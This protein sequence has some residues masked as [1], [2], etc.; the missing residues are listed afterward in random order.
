VSAAGARGQGRPLRIGIVGPIGCGKSTVA[1]WL[2]ELGAVVIDA[3]RVARR[4]TPPGSAPLA[5][6]VD[7]FGRRV[8]R[9]DGTLD[10]TALGRIVFADPAQLARLEAIIHPAVRP[11]IIELLAAADAAY[12][13]GQGGTPGSPAAIVIEAI[14]LVEGGLAA[15]CDEVWL[16]TCD[17]TIQRK[18]IAVRGAAA[19]Q[20]PDPTDTE[21]R[22]AAQAD[23]VERLRPSATRII[24]TSGTKAATRSRIEA[25][26]EAALRVRA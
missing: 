16:V 25:A 22:I 23:L 8:L 12:V 18:R 5:A 21:A 20:S 24:D 19:G 13:T 17:P 15:L 7:A 11:R 6:V 3:D 9:G 2:G 1:G 4:L 26:F 10:R 14:K